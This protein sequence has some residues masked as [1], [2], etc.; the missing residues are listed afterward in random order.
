MT[1]YSVGDQVR[2]TATRGDV[3][4]GTVG[5]VQ[6][7]DWEDPYD[8]GVL[9]DDYGFWW[10]EEH[11]LEKA[12]ATPDGRVHFDGGG[13][14]DTQNGKPRFDLLMPV[15]VSYSEQFLTRCAVHMAK[16]AE[17]YEDRNWEQFSDQDSLD[18][19]KSSALRHMM[20]WLSGET[21]EDH[22]AAVFFNLMA[23]EYIKGRMND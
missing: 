6:A 14:R 19:A 10:T 3:P 21:D 22:A 9:F 17:K 12:D 4:V 1:D 16:G 7:L 15:E 18:R 20:Q 11:R 2:L 13:M 23:A 8:I 5:T